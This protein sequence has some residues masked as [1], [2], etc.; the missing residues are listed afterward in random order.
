VDLLRCD[1]QFVLISDS[2][3]RSSETF[4]LPVEEQVTT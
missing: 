2:T 4:Y 1:I 3:V